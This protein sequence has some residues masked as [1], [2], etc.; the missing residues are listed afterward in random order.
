MYDHAQHGPS[1]FQDPFSPFPP[2]IQL[3]GNQQEIKFLPMIIRNVCC[4]V[5]KQGKHGVGRNGVKGREKK[6]MVLQEQG[7]YKVTK[8]RTVLLTYFSL[9]NFWAYSGG[10]FRVAFA[11]LFQLLR[12]PSQCLRLLVTFHLVCVPL[13]TSQS[14]SCSLRP[15]PSRC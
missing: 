14:S 3:F 11:V 12:V 13:L 8:G 7:R 6:T 9:L 5:G 10:Q 1:L 4:G 15:H 2:T